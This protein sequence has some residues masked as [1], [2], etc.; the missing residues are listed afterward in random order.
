MS[1]RL[2]ILL[3]LLMVV[4]FYTALAVYIQRWIIL[5][6]F[7]AMERE[8]A[9]EDLERCRKA[10][11]REIG[12]V[13]S[14]CLDWSSWDDSYAFV[15]DHN[16]DFVK[17]NLDVSWFKQIN[18]NLLYFIDKSGAVVWGKVYDLET[19]KEVELAEFP[20]R[21]WDPAH[22]LLQH[23]DTTTASAGVLATEKAPLIIVSRA[24][25]N[26]N[27]EGMSRGTM[28]MG[29][30]LTKKSIEAIQ[31]QI[32]IRFELQSL[33]SIE[34]SS[35]DAGE[36]LTESQYVFSE[37]DENT[38]SARSGFLD[39]YGRNVFVIESET[40]RDITMRGRLVASQAR[41]LFASVSTIVLLGVLLVLQRSVIDPIRAFTEHVTRLAQADELQQMAGVRRNDE[42]GALTHE[43]NNMV[44]HIQ[45]NVAERQR[46]EDALRESEARI[47][48]IVETAP[49]GIIT[50]SDSGRIESVNPAAERLFCQSADD[51]VGTY[52][53]GLIPELQK[54]LVELTGSQ[55]EPRGLPLGGE[56]VGVREGGTRF[57]LHWTLGQ[58]FFADRRLYTAIVRDITEWKEMGEKVLRAQHMAAIGEMGAT[59]AHEIR[60]PLA[61]ISAVVQI[62][63]DG[64]PEGDARR[65]RA[66]DVIENVQRV[67]GIVRRLLLYARSW[68]PQRQLIDMRELV[69][70]I[71]AKAKEQERW[72]GVRFVYEGQ[73][74]VRALVD[75]S[76]L[77]QVLW[78]I[79]DN[80]LDALD[81]AR[82]RQPGG[83]PEIVFAF[84]SS[85]ESVR[86]SIRDTGGG[87][88]PEVKDKLFRPL[89]TTKTYGTG[90]G[91]AICR[92]IMEAHGGRLTVASV[93][94]QG[95]EVTLDFPGKESV[96][97]NANTRG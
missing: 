64:F 59:I 28:L 48:A 13:D 19:E 63:R 57:P 7:S 29:R 10:I 96:D 60:N 69:E 70:D 92:R 11:Q 40:L 2:R 18:V 23:V 45:K 21:K 8:E 39:V 33:E 42:I 56:G 47:R 31:D 17:A 81:A 37:L 14:F 34:A 51:L 71:V 76:L 50:M 3:S 53:F 54:K 9:Q 90:L 89:F 80:A 26:S 88:T 27:Q 83:L 72:A 15:V 25:L 6:S 67:E 93:V 46:A 87:M 97:G 62:L 43:F 20:R 49:D 22:P 73:T 94:G 41:I 24:I 44:R 86:L 78:N 32:R 35:K 55:G 16:E 91:L 84:S 4:L 65:E 68:E 1:L 30:F 85:Q 95:T 52:V 77:R 38:L 58:T 61:G 36:A 66:E 74:S 12:V 82:N 75:P 79:L 5:P